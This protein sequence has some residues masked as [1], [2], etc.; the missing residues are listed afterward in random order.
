MHPS[1][2]DAAKHRSLVL[3]SLTGPQPVTPRGNVGTR[4]CSVGSSR[5]S[6][7]PTRSP[8]CP[9][10]TGLTCLIGIFAGSRRVA[11]GCV[12]DRLADVGCIFTRV[13]SSSRHALWHFPILSA[14]AAVLPAGAVLALSARIALMRM[15]PLSAAGASCAEQQGASGRQQQHRT[16]AFC[17][18]PIHH[19]R[20]VP[21]YAGRRPRRP[22]EERAQA[23]CA[24]NPGFVRP[25]ATRSLFP[26]Q[27]EHAGDH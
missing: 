25:P 11:P 20:L 8:D 5:W 4:K 3:P 16:A 24:G 12:A 22:S 9:C 26:L 14:N 18:H 7:R 13:I 27:T 15:R 2:P 19:F 6:R 23:R 21:P 17:Q 1:A 10:V